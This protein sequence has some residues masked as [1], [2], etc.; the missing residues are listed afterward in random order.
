MAWAAASRVPPARRWRHVTRSRTAAWATMM[1]IAGP[2][3]LGGCLADGPSKGVAI[4][5]LMSGTVA[6]YA[7]S[8]EPFNGL[9]G[10][11][12]VRFDPATGD[13]LY[14]VEAEV[15]RIRFGD[16]VPVISPLGSVDEGFPVDAEL[17]RGTE[18]VHLETTF[19]SQ[20]AGSLLVVDAVR[21]SFDGGPADEEIPSHQ[22]GQGLPD[23]MLG[24][25]F[26]GRTLV[27]GGFSTALQ[28]P[29]DHPFGRFTDQ[30]LQWQITVVDDMAQVD[31]LET[32][33]FRADDVRGMSMTW[34]SSCP[35]PAS[36]DMDM[37]EST[38]FH[39][40]RLTCAP[41]LDGT[42]LD[43]STQDRRISGPS[44]F[45]VK[46]P[47]HAPPLSHM[48]SFPLRGLSFAEAWDAIQASVQYKVHCPSEADC[49]YP[50]LRFGLVSCDDLP[51]GREG[52]CLACN[53]KERAPGWAVEAIHLD[54]QEA[55]G[56]LGVKCGS[57]VAV[58]PVDRWADWAD[59]LDPE[60][61]T[62]W[63]LDSPALASGLEF[64]TAEA[65]TFRVAFDVVPS[66]RMPVYGGPRPSAGPVTLAMDDLQVGHGPIG[67]GISVSAGFVVAW[68]AERGGLLGGYAGALRTAQWPAE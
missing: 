68:A 40:E 61:T 55:Q 2:V 18:V 25:W 49:W 4:P 27:E 34:D 67:S 13:D 38:P 44:P 7:F 56:F 47:V 50:S 48:A 9:Q 20:R 19:M 53:T 41:G 23:L 17:V 65:K 15:L 63:A 33:R 16:P 31:L 45:W 1:A 57:M 10:A 54:R 42:I 64:M 58:Y 28:V 66:E 39:A 29:P 8:G 62:L 12:S 46:A 43:L 51:G 60:Q 3:I 35:L 26:A 32:D 6:T 21:A 59:G 30:P 24:T 37:A 22:W 11:G 5:P 14:P 36:L 52:A